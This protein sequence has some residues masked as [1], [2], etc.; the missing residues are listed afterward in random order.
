MLDPD[1]VAEAMDADPDQTLALLARMSAATDQR[2]RE[3]ARQMAGRLTIEVGRGGS[4]NRSGT[5][6]LRRAALRDAH[7]DI[8]LDASLDAVVALRSGTSSSTDGIYVQEWQRPSTALCLLVDRSGSMAGDRL[9]TAAVAAATVMLRAPLDC[10]VVAFGE[11]AIV[12][13]SQ[14]QLRSPEDVVTDVLQLRGFGV[15]DL[16]CAL[17]VAA[18]QLSRSSAGH[19]VTLLMSDCRVTAGG[20]PLAHVAG[21]HELAVLAPAGDTAD[22]AAFAA[23]TGARWSELTGPT[24]VPDAINAV[25][26]G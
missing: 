13:K 3:L 14:D 17:R 15:T 26:L 19:R 11:D 22:A 16:A 25:L 23:S 2:L 4:A 21:T 24:G 7:G 18:A 9:A 10:S 5:G 12:L 8:D 20:D 6:R 1:A